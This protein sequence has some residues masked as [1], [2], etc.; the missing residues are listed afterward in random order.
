[1]PPLTHLLGKPGTA[2]ATKRIARINRGLACL[3]NTGIHMRPR[4]SSP[5][6]S[7]Y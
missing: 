7:E 4:M 3:T 2:G 6:L 5:L 1:M